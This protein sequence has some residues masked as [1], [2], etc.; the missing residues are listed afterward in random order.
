M[1]DPVPAADDNPVAVSVILPT[2]NRADLLQRSIGSVLRQTADDLELIVVDDGSED[3]TADVID[4]CEDP[5]LRYLKLERNSG[6]SAAR[7]AGLDYARGQFLAFQDSDDEWH[8]SKLERELQAFDSNPGA[9]VVYGDMI[10]HLQDG[11]R[12]RLRS[13]D[14]VR[15]RL[16]NPQTG[17]WQTY[18]LAMQ[19]CLIRRNRLMD[20]RFD[21]ELHLF[22]DLD[23][24]L[25][26]AF[27]NDYV[28]IGEP[29]VTYHESDGLTADPT[30]EHRA[31]WRLV[32]KHGRLL[33][34][35]APG[36]ALQEKINILLRRSLMPIVQQHLAPL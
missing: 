2:Y 33:R 27:E 32:N 23:L 3:H 21:E 6:L 24:H 26:L 36:F 18:M 31:R 28:S 12:M 25:R 14:I 22:E 1:S 4:A 5:R 10:R 11:S 35:E 13:P 34:R 29:L 7:N 20:L 8:Q 19:P 30:R 17:F 16:I 9:A 15:G